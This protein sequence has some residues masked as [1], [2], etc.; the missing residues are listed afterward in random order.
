MGEFLSAL[1]QSDPEKQ[2][3]VNVHTTKYPMGAI[4]AQLIDEDS[5]SLGNVGT[6]QGVVSNSDQTP[7]EVS[8]RGLMPLLMPACLV[9]SVEVFFL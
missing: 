1:K 3:Y 6:G 8:S 7:G 5:Q 4:R 9:M 2:F